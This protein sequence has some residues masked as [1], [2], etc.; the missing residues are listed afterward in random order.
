VG[1][2]SGRFPAPGALSR[3]RKPSGKKAMLILVH[4]AFKLAIL[5]NFTSR[6]GGHRVRLPGNRALCSDVLLYIILHD[7]GR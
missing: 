5:G 2:S 3:A 7:D 1:C 6:Q 4:V